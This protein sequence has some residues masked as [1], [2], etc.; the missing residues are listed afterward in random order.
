[1]HRREITEA[2]RK[3][4]MR[5][6]SAAVA[7]T[8]SMAAGPVVAPFA[9]VAAAGGPRAA[10]TQT[11]PERGGSAVALPSGALVKY[12]DEGAAVAAVQKVVGVDDDGIF[13]PITRGAVERFQSRAGLP[14][15]GTVDA[16]TWATMFRSQVSYVGKGGSQSVT[17]DYR[18]GGATAPS[19]GVDGP[20]AAAPKPVT[21]TKKKPSS[22]RTAT[23]PRPTTEPTTSTDAAKNRKAITNT[24]AVANPAPAPAAAPVSTGAGCGS[25]QI[26]S[27][28]AGTTTGSFGENR[29]SHA[30]AGKDI[31]APTGTAV[32]A[33]QCGTVTK[34][35]WDNG[36]Y[37]NLV[38]IEHE[39]GVST[40]YA[41]LSSV[42]TKV[43]QYVHVGD[44]VGKVGSTGRSTGPHL[45][46]E[47]RENGKA[48]NPDNY[49]SG[50]K[51]IAGA[52]PKTAAGKSSTGSLAVT[53]TGSAAEWGE[54]TAVS[55][56]QTEAT[57]A[58][59]W[60][61]EAAAN[62]SY[63]VTATGTA[64]AYGAPAGAAPAAATPGV[65]DPAAAAPAADPAAKVGG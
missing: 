52:A 34:A 27:P 39:G 28:V 12:G 2:A 59:A 64:P 54:A 44:V 40:C 24:Q 48:V 61:A 65:T 15:T 58:A 25:G 33:A 21:K 38:C 19:A 50:S 49:L 42:D 10:A 22:N 41:H 63:A 35:G 56:D 57:L 45:H 11:A 17:V 31:S 43:G 5:R 7:V 16:K 32:R 8:A 20:S 36:G 51:T 60:E 37:G 23:T 13:G 14:V 9:A 1:M 26:A 55:A 62:A 53:E 46:F 3:H 4:A 30:H 18:N 6:K 29:G 47:V